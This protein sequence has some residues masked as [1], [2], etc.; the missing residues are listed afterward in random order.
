M[1]AIDEVKTW[2]HPEVPYVRTE[3]NRKVVPGVHAVSQAYDGKWHYTRQLHQVSLF[4][5][6]VL[7]PLEQTADSITMTELPTHVRASIT[8][9]AETT[10]LLVNAKKKA[11]FETFAARGDMLVPLNDHGDTYEAGYVFEYRSIPMK[12]VETY[13]NADFDAAKV[14]KAP[15]GAMAFF[16]KFGRMVIDTVD[17][18]WAI[19]HPK[20][21]AKEAA[22]AE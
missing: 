3:A 17:H 21:A 13:L 9:T 4:G 20:A 18:E 1:A 6:Q 5:Q 22:T 8:K 12:L 16:H 11:L 19:A 14:T 2:A 15:Q 7:V 10:L